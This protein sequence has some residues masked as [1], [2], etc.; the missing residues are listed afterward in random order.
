VE[1]ANELMASFGRIFDIYQLEFNYKK[2]VQWKDSWKEGN[3]LV[4]KMMVLAKEYKS[5]VS[6]LYLS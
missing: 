4:Q 6:P 1:R 5:I 2:R 3:I